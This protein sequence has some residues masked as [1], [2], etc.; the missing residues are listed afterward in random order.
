MSLSTCSTSRWKVPFHPPS[1]RGWNTGKTDRW[2]TERDFPAPGG[3]NNPSERGNKMRER[4]SPEVIQADKLWTRVRDK[5]AMTAPS[6]T[7]ASDAHVPPLTGCITPRAGLFHRC[8]RRPGR[9]HNVSSAADELPER[10][11]EGTE[12]RAVGEDRHLEV[13][14]PLSE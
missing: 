14:T 8:Y 9:P 13:L 4:R 1:F 11:V 5:P 7:S 6:A 10:L 2:N 12:V 3:K